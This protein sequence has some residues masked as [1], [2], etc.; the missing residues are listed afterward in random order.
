MKINRIIFLAIILILLNSCK[1]KETASEL[2]QKSIYTIDTIESIYYKQNMART[3]PQNLNDTIFR[4]REMYFNRLPSD[5]I[6][7]VKGHWYMYVNDKEN[8]VFEDIYDG[9]RLVRKNNQDSIVKIYDLIKFPDF[10]SKHFW[11]HNTLYA[12]QFEYKYML[13]NMDCYSIERL[14]DTIVE[15]KS[16]FQILVILKNKMTMPGFASKLEDNKGSISKKILFIDRNTYYPIKIKEEFY[17]TDNP[18]Q[19]VFVDQTYYDIK[20]NVTINEVEQYNVS[21]ES[22]EGYE[23]IEMKPE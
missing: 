17:S 19:K 12:M 11:G 7:G 20:F 23:I 3:N 6:V 8:L 16:C 1:E 15:S 13:D 22:F 4:Y 2:I 18:D 5:S 14:N 21:D 10:R 9:N